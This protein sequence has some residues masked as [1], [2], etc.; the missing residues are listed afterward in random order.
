MMDGRGGELGELRQWPS[1]RLARTTRTAGCYRLCPSRRGLA[2][3]SEGL[4]C[5]GLEVTISLQGLELHLVD[6]TPTPIFSGL[7]RLDDGMA[8]GAVMPGCVPVR[9]GIAAA[10]VAAGQAEPQVHPSVSACQA[11]G[12]ALRTGRDLP[13]FA[14]VRTGLLWP[15]HGLTSP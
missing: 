13:D 8:R 9:R 2:A 10:D 3:A 12:T 7:E 5:P 1:A 11:F 15:G 14:E 6:V 4:S